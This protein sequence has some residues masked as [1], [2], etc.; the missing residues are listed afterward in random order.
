MGCVYYV[1]FGLWS[2]CSV[3][4]DATKWKTFVGIWHL[5][6]TYKLILTDRLTEPVSLRVFFNEFNYDLQIAMTRRRYIYYIQI[7][8]TY[9]HNYTLNL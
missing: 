1:K 4:N 5:G 8:K 6:E 3:R 7:N 9:T 2:L